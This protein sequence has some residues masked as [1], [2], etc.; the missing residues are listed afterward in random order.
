MTVR[1]EWVNRAEADSI[2]VYRSTSAFD[3]ASLPSVLATLD[4]NAR[5]YDDNGVSGETAYFY[6]IAIVSGASV[7][8]TGLVTITTAAS[9]GGAAILDQ[10]GAT[11]TDQ[12]GTAITE[13]G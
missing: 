9:G 11:I 6:R 3:G 2:R 8:L 5:S 12:A 7:A 10:L 1:L 13:Q 4:A